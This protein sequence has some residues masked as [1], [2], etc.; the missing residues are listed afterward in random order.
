MVLF[1]KDILG[2]EVA[3]IQTPPGTP[4][5]PFAAT[6]TGAKGGFLA[7]A[8][9]GVLVGVRLCVAA[10]AGERVNLSAGIILPALAVLV[11]AGGAGAAFAVLQAGHSATEK[12]FDAVLHALENFIEGVG[13]FVS[14]N[15]AFGGLLFVL[16][17]VVGAPAVLVSCLVTAGIVAWLGTVVGGAIALL[18]ALAGTLGVGAGVGYGVGW[19]VGCVLA[20]LDLGST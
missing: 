3:F 6:E 16:I 10:F 4:P 11:V 8:L 18:A 17:V 13:S 5:V 2:L 7:G 19:V 20:S 1:A 15:L 12:T 9:T 14:A